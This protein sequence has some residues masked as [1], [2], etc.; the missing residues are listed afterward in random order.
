MKAESQFYTKTAFVLNSVSVSKIWELFESAGLE[1][2]AT[3]ECADG[4]SRK[5]KLLSEI[6]GYDNARR[7]QITV[8][9]LTGYSY[10]LKSF[11]TV[12]M[13]GSH[14]TTVSF[15]LNGEAALVADMRIKLMDIIDGMKPWF[16]IIARFDFVGVVIAL[17]TA[18]GV[19]YSLLGSNEP[20]AVV[21]PSQAFYATCLIIGFFCALILLAWGFKKLRHKV[22]PLAVFEIGQGIKREEVADKI[23][24]SVIVALCVGVL[25]SF[26]FKPFA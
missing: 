14:S 16:D 23:R 11:S 2:E 9:R 25:G 19:Y 1:V 5:V 7:A 6:V 21:A 8:F 15:S 13:G 20:K 22:F 4:I 12:T 3:L 26:L 17:L 24:W 10:E 18:V